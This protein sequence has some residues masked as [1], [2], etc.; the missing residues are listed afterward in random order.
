MIRRG[1]WIFWIAAMFAVLTDYEKVAGKV[2]EI[3]DQH[4]GQVC[5]IAAVN[6]GKQFI[7]SGDLEL[8]TH[9]KEI[10]EKAS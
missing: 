3:K 5:D 7:M 1:K 8:L 9:V 6:S 2:Q 10:P 4:P